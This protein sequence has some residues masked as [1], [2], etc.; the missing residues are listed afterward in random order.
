MYIVLQ[1]VRTCRLPLATCTYR[2]SLEVKRLSASQAAAKDIVRLS[3]QIDS[4][5]SSIDLAQSHDASHTEE[6][7][8]QRW[9][10]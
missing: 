6:L 7:V 10:E 2:A 9:G 8:R 5:E 4:L 3:L 1:S